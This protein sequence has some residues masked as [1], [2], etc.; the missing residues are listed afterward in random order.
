MGRRGRRDG[1]G[2]AAHRQARRGERGHSR[3]KSEGRSISYDEPVDLGVY[4]AM[5]EGVS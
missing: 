1:G 4:D 5:L 3:G 2:P